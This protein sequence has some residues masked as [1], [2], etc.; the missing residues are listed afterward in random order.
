MILI[1]SW[2]EA[3]NQAY[4]VRYAVFVLEQGIPEVL[5]LDEFVLKAT[6]ALAF[7]NNQCVGTARLIKIS[8]ICGQIGRMAVLADYRQQ[9]I[10]GQLLG[11]LIE[12]GKEQ[13]MV[14]YLLH[15]QLAAIPFY[16]KFGFVPQGEVYDEA[17]CL[18]RNMMLLI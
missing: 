1:Q 13:G 8:S 15:A 2:D 11:A 10:G 4:P 16:E 14:E 5:E 18:H 12:Y 3:E 9:G 7:F 6:H 17:G